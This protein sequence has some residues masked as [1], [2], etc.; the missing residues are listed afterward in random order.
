M[1]EPVSP[2]PGPNTMLI[3]AMLVELPPQSGD[4]SALTF[5]QIRARA[6]RSIL[7]SPQFMARDRVTAVYTMDDVIRLSI[8]PKQLSDDDVLLDI[9]LTGE[10]ETTASRRFHDGQTIVIPATAI[11]RPNAKAVLVLRQHVIRE[12]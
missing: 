5:E 3:E 1:P 10:A 7:T 2:A 4:P 9:E 12:T 6:D 11:A 8:T